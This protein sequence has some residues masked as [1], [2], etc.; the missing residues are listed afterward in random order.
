MKVKD[1]KRDREL[2]FRGEI[3][4]DGDSQINL[5]RERER[6][7]ISNHLLLSRLQARNQKSEG[8]FDPS[9]IPPGGRT[10]GGSGGGSGG[11]LRL[12]QRAQKS[13]PPLSACQ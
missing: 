2:R 10:R 6:A 13:T 5:E 1:R 9:T 11:D 4:R 7:V 3:E 12:Q 8:N